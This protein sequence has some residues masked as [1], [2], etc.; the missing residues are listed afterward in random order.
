MSKRLIITG[1]ALLVFSCVAWAAERTIIGVVSDEHCGVKHS[2]ASDEAA[3]CVR[4]CVAGGAK[5][6]LVHKGK[7]YKLDAQEKFADFAGRRVKVTG[8]VQDDSITVSS[9]EAAPGKQ[10]TKKEPAA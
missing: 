4:K 8:T 10:K 5:Y 2:T 6:V 3:A 9:V 7:V 1:F